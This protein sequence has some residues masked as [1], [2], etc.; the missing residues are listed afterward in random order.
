M[1]TLTTKATYKNGIII[2]KAKPSFGTPDEVLVTFVKLTGPKTPRYGGNSLAFLET[3]RKYKGILPKD[4]PSG[5]VYV[6]KLR[7]RLTAEWEHRL[8]K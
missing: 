8:A 5:K 3:L 4:F 1:A 7:K 2:P 6:R